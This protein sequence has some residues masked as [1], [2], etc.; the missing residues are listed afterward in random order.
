MKICWNILYVYDIS[1]CQTFLTENTTYHKHANKGQTS[2]FLKNKTKSNYLWWY[3][4]VS[5]KTQ[6]VAFSDAHVINVWTVVQRHRKIRDCKMNSS[7]RF[8][9]MALRKQVPHVKRN[10]FSLEKVNYQFAALRSIKKNFRNIYLL[11]YRHFD[12]IVPI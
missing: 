9:G 6:A 8:L 4:V 5:S 1:N 11:W 3:I 7:K 2:T 10:S 12:A